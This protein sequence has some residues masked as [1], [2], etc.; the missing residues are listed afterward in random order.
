MAAVR[1][2]IDWLKRLTYGLRPRPRVKRH[3]MDRLLEI[4]REAG[5]TG[6]W[7]PEADR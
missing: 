7:R 5:L 6:I 2:A 3:Q 1:G 4:R